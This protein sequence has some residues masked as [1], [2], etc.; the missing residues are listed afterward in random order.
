MTQVA[1]I[2]CGVVGAAIAYELSKV[3]GFNITLLDENTPASGATGAALGI[4]MAIISHKVKGRAWQL[5]HTSLQRY[6]SLIPELEA[7]TGLSIPYHRQGILKLTTDS[8]ELSKWQE[9]VKIRAQ[10]GLDLQVWDA[11]QIEDHCPQIEISSNQIIG[12][13]YSPQDRQVNPSLLTQALVQGA[14]HNGVDCLFGVKVTELIS[15]SSGHCTAIDTD[16]GIIKVDAVVIAA[17]IGSTPL[18]K[19]LNIRPVLGQALHVKLAQNLG[20]NQFQPIITGNDVHILPVGTGEYWLGATVEFESSD[21]ELTADPTQLTA[22]KNQAIAFCPELANCEILSTWSGLRPR[23]Q[24]H[25]APVIEN[26]SGYNNVILATGHY[27]NGVL[28]A[29]ATAI[30]VVNELNNFYEF[31][32]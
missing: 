28:L 18:I 5:R 27:R 11:S 29:P 9:L 7:L 16:Q 30:A 8:S 14:N 12:A 10:Q 6:E 19:S 31:F 22:V 3:A 20:N 13:L 32:K 17:G 15:E 2:G 4:M 1:V 24:G 26:L 23:P 21:Q 25:P